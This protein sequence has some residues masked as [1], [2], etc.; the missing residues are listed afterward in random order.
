VVGDLV[1][2]VADMVPAKHTVRLVDPQKTILLMVVGDGAMLSV[3]EDWHALHK[4]NVHEIR[5]GAAA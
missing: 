2:R 4:F 3:V 1:R 5:K